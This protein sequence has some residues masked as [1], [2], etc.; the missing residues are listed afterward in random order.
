MTPSF[1]VHA[2]KVQIFLLYIFYNTNIMKKVIST[3]DKTSRL[4]ESVSDGLIPVPEGM[5]R[6]SG[7]VAKMNVLNNNGRFYT[8]ANYTKHI[9]SIQEKIRDGLYGELEHPEH[10]NINLNN[11]SHKIE[12]L[13]YDHNTDEVKTIM[14]LLDDEKGKKAQSIVKSGGTLRCSTRCAGDTTSDNRA[15]ISKFYTIDLV[16]TP[17]FS[18]AKLHLYE[19]FGFESKEVKDDKFLLENDQ[20]IVFC[21]EINNML[22]ESKGRTISED[23]ALLESLNRRTQIAPKE[24]SLYE[25]IRH[26]VL[27]GK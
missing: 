25:S 18:E 24:K 13:W 19:S 3:I 15:V 20:T 11:V 7:V 27:F 14:L 21:S 2:V 26:E 23:R 22:L 6:V 9:D 16:G 1:E 12:K 10:F 8:K 5:M 17:G 4:Y